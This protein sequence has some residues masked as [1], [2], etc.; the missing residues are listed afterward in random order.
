VAYVSPESC[1]SRLPLTSNPGLMPPRRDAPPGGNAPPT[2][3]APPGGEARPVPPSHSATSDDPGD[4]SYLKVDMTE[5]GDQLGVRA[6]ELVAALRAHEGAVEYGQH[7]GG[8]GERGSSAS[9][10]PSAVPTPSAVPGTPTDAPFSPRQASGWVVFVQGEEMAETPTTGPTGNLSEVDWLPPGESL[11]EAES[12]PMAGLMDDLICSMQQVSAEESLLSP[13]RRSR[14]RIPSRTA[15]RLLP[16]L[17]A[18]L[19]AS[20]RE[21]FDEAD[22]IGTVS[23]P[24]AGSAAAEE[25]HLQSGFLFKVTDGGAAAMRA[26]AMEPEGGE[27][28]PGTPPATICSLMEHE[29]QAEREMETA[30]AGTPFAAGRGDTYAFAMPDMGGAADPQVTFKS[31]AL[32]SDITSV[33]LKASEAAGGA[34][35]EV[36][37]QLQLTVQRRSPVIGYVLLALAVWGVSAL[38]AGV[39]MLG[40]VHPLV[41]SLWR[42]ELAFLVFTPW[43]AATAFTNLQCFECLRDMRTIGCFL[44]TAVSSAGYA[45]LFVMSLTYTTMATAF[46]LGNCHSL[47]I[48]SWRLITGSK[49]SAMEGL[50]VFIGLAGAAITVLDKE[51]PPAPTGPP[52]LV[53]PFGPVEVDRE[54]FGAGLALASGVCGALYI[55]SAGM[56]RPR[57]EFSAFLWLLFLA[58]AGIYALM[59]ALLALLEGQPLSALLS[60]G[61]DPLTGFFGW[62]A[63]ANLWP[64]V[65]MG[66]IGTI[67]GMCCYIGVM[68]YLDSVVVSVAMLSEPFVGVATG[69]L[70]HV[71]TWPGPFGWA[72]STISVLG[73]L[74]VIAG[75]RRKS[76]SATVGQHH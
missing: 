75:T 16:D 26:D 44:L 33:E 36:M 6:E 5:L 46:L 52:M 14:S 68:K 11:V 13:R 7:G 4:S 74:I 15:S 18:P 70:L 56:T 72:G 22:I 66:P 38:G 76:V 19:L 60:M 20:R 47:L 9:R 30:A 10:L 40:D 50:G 34:E 1:I 3:G 51:K 12:F 59:L 2:N 45:G 64:S 25:A 17:E 39:R 41:K 8:G 48:V 58:H 65:M 71:S 63:P 42:C 61:A 31:L 53:G 62:L 55:T 54:T 27:L 43:L 49:V 57:M 21:S 24:S 28:A 69:V 37:P 73:A 67:L 29:L 32:P 35:G 23:L